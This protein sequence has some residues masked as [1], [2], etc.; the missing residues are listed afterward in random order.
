M[1]ASK[2]IVFDIVGTCISYDAFF[3]AIEERLGDKLRHQGIPPRLFG[4]LVLEG[5]EREC[6]LSKIARHP[7]PFM[8]MIKPVFYRLLAMSGIEKPHEF[9]ADEDVTYVAESYRRLGARPGIHEC[10]RR[11]RENGFTIWALTS[12]DK[13]RVQDYL[14]AADIDIPT[15]NFIACEMIGATK[16]EP[17]VYEHML[18][19]FPV[20]SETWF[21]ACHMWDAAAAKRS[22]CVLYTE[23]DIVAYMC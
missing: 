6:L 7:I 13:A 9:A 12:G 21:A 3:A 11:L 16:P 8:E 23:N 10:M 22:G 4:L 20:A 1:T 17:E 14:K 18:K 5:G 19:M 2:H 15:E